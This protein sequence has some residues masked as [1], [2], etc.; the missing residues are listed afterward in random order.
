MQVN[1]NFNVADR[2]E[3]ANQGNSVQKGLGNNSFSKSN[4]IFKS[5]LGNFKQGSTSQFSSSLNISN[6]INEASFKR[7]SENYLKNNTDV[8]DKGFDIDDK[9]EDDEE[10]TSTK[11]KALD[12]NLQFALSFLSNQAN[13]V[14]SNQATDSKATDT[15]LQNNELVKLNSKQ[16]ENALNNSAQNASLEGDAENLANSNTSNL[17]KEGS[18]ILSNTKNAFAEIESSD[19]E[20]DLNQIK[21]GLNQIKDD[22][23]KLSSMKK[24]DSEQNLNQMAKDA[25]VTS[26]SL[27]DVVVD[28]TPQNIEQEDLSLEKAFKQKSLNDLNIVNEEKV[29]SSAKEG[30][31]K[32]K[33]S[34]QIKQQQQGT[35]AKQKTD[36]AS[37]AQNLSNKVSSALNTLRG[38]LT[39]KAE[40]NTLESS[41][42]AKSAKNILASATQTLSQVVSG[43]SEGQGM[44]SSNG[45]S[46]NNLFFG[47]QNNMQFTETQGST[48]SAK[49]FKEH[50]NFTRNTDE[51][52]K[53]LANKVMKM[54]SKNLKEMEIDLDPKNLGKMKITVGINKDND[55]AS[56]SIAAS[57]AQTKE[58]LEGSLGKLRD[59][60]S[61]NGVETEANIY[62][63]LEQ[64]N[65]KGQNQHEGSESKQHKHQENKDNLEDGLI[66]AQSEDNSLEVN[67]LTQATKDLR[68]GSTS[69]QELSFFA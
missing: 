8:K 17:V 60:L 15:L 7:N 35:D 62:D 45:Q 53:E 16:I 27:R 34:E 12:D 68:F 22:L 42:L 25:K 3:V 32:W 26:V 1:S 47:M 50:M 66:F 48:M 4:D 13:D 21:D 29:D 39:K 46:Q 69:N 5:I 61:Q 20:V 57:N 11:D 67:Y 65:H 23:N 64:E 56:V 18:D 51:N 9:D 19:I 58:L 33:I 10:K 30:S 28:E 44:Q 54:A 41:N 40:A 52:A 55:A 59:I 6:N 38:A 37:V 14:T 24:I 49:T 43:A 31:N 2:A 36:N 63:Y